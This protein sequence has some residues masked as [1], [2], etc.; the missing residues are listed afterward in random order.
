MTHIQVEMLLGCVRW[1]TLSTLQPVLGGR[2]PRW[3]VQTN[4]STQTGT[5]ESA[6]ITI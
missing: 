1:Y 2:V 5:S 6:F 4:F 3:E